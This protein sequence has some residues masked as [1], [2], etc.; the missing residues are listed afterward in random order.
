MNPS[1]LKDKVTVRAL[2]QTT[3]SEGTVI[4]TYSDSFKRFAE[5]RPTRGREPYVNDQFLA[6]IDL[7][8]SMRFDGQ[9][10]NITAKNEITFK[11]QRLRI[12]GPPINVE[13][14]DKEIR[15]FCTRFADGR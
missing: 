1:K 13:N 3:D 8:V 4:D 2:T 12:I 9:T 5:V 15:L 11:G 7:V 6:E 10:R 14:Q